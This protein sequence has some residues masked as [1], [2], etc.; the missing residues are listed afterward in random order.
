MKFFTFPELQ[1]DVVQL[2]SSD[3][4]HGQEIRITNGCPYSLTKEHRIKSTSGF[5][6]SQLS[7]GASID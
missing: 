6:R 5:S 2:E 1:T 7:D 4:K 3:G